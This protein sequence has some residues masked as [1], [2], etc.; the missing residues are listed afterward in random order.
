M[1][2]ETRVSERHELSRSGCQR[3]RSSAALR[4][5]YEEAGTHDIHT[6]I[7]GESITGIGAF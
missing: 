6:L 3:G 4:S 1:L 5:P 2:F 7:I